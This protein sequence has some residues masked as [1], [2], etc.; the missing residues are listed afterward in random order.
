L[1]LDY[2]VRSSSNVAFPKDLCFL[3]T[4]KRI[5]NPVIWLILSALYVSR[6]L[7]LPPIPSYESITGEHLF[8][9]SIPL[10]KH[11]PGFWKHLGFRHKHDVPFF[12]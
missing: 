10:Y 12:S 5:G 11:I 7:E 8:E 9:G 1:S 3:K 2:K 4:G 6:G